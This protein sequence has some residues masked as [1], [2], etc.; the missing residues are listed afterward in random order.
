MRTTISSF[1]RRWQILTVSPA[2]PCCGRWRWRNQPFRKAG[3]ER[4]Q[5]RIRMNAK[6]C[7]LSAITAGLAMAMIAVLSGAA[8]AETTLVT[9]GTAGGPLPRPDRAQSS[10][11]LIVNDTLYLIDAG[12]G[13]T[14]RIV[15]SGNNFRKV[16]KIF[17]THAHSDHTAGL[18]TLLVSQWEQQAEPADIY[19]SGVEALVK[20]AIDYLT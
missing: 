13:V 5:G 10:N 15:Q 4:K 14:G 12:G 6:Q 16:S 3:R 11:L 2:A 18:A 8:Q 7:A 9:L 19:G 17:I 1:W 20:G